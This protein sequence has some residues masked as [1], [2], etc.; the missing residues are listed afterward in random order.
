MQVYIEY[1]VLDNLIVDFVLLKE[2]AVLLRLPHGWL[3]IFLASVAGTAVAVI[4]PVIGLKD[5]F[6]VIVKVMCALV[7][8]F[9]AV[10]HGSVVGYFKYLG[11]FLAMTFLLGGTVIGI[12]SLIGIPYDAEAYYSNKLLPIGL[13][14]LAAYLTVKLV[15]GFIK[16]A[17]P[18]IMLAA[19]RYEAE[20]T[21]NGL[22]FK[23]VA[24][25]D[26]GNRL[27]D[28]KTGLPIIVCSAKLFGR[29]AKKTNLIK[30]GELYYV[31]A[32]GESRSDYYSIDTVEI[33]TGGGKK[34]KRAYIMKGEVFLSDADMIV[35][36]EVIEDIL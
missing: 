28:T 22:T 9:I 2:S 21:V 33:K 19:D 5:V 1:A 35:G 11:V 32:A 25:F 15:T 26:N 8:S 14:V 31:T 3:R 27:K 24:F 18:S 23:S 10:D 16:R 20:I 6:G 36:R 12:L 17:V 29:I 7:I 4:L 34:K 30:G 13:N